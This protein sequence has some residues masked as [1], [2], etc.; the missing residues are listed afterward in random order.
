MPVQEDDRDDLVIR[1]VVRGQENRR[2]REPE[3]AE[4]VTAPQ[5]CL[6]QPKPAPSWQALVK[7]G[8]P[9]DAPG[10]PYLSYHVNTPST[11]SH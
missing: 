10:R 3:R 9:Y 11:D 4:S 8:V 7:W 2:P 6:C 1:N 5:G